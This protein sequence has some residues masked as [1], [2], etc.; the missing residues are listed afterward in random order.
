MTLKVIL[1]CLTSGDP[2]WVTVV[3][4]VMAMVWSMRRAWSLLSR[5]AMLLMK[6]PKE[7]TAV[8]RTW[9]SHALLLTTEICS[10]H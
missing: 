2:S 5:D 1:T 8:P 3:A 4:R 7:N 10:F 9:N 6:V